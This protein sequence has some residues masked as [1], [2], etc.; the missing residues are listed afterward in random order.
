MVEEKKLTEKSFWN[1]MAIGA[2]GAYHLDVSATRSGPM[3]L[4]NTISLASM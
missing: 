2:I 3:M 1:S 4:K